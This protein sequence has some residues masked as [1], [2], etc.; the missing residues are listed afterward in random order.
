[1]NLGLQINLGPRERFINQNL[2]VAGNLV[3]GGAINFVALSVNNLTS[4]NINNSGTV[5]SA[6][7]AGNGSAL[8]GVLDN[9]NFH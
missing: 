5:T 2:N 4:T 7:F 1:M 3:V 8:T 9:T 6:S